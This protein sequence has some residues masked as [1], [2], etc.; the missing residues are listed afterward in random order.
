MQVLGLCTN[1]S[2]GVAPPIVAG[3]DDT[4]WTLVCAA[5]DQNSKETAL[6]RR[7]AH[8]APDASHII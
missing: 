3:C 4:E 1:P 5:I 8:I 7:V 6:V 2:N